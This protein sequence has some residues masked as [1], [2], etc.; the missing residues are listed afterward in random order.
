MEQKVKHVYSL[1]PHHVKSVT[2]VQIPGR[3]LFWKES[4]QKMAGL[5]ESFKICFEGDSVELW[6]WIQRLHWVDLLDWINVLDLIQ[7]TEARWLTWDQLLSLNPRREA[8][9]NR[10]WKTFPRKLQGFVQAIAKSKKKS[11]WKAHTLLSPHIQTQ[12]LKVKIFDSAPVQAD[13]TDPE[14]Q[15]IFL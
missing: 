4:K 7:W 2:V 10:F 3:F 9:A 12:S 11:N 1:P 14:L 13:G 5:C 6:I 8:M 15:A